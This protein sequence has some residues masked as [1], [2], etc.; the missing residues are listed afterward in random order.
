M[1]KIEVPAKKIIGL[2]PPANK[3]FISDSEKENE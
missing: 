1:I 2:D 3:K